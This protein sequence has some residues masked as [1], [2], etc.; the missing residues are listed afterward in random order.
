[1][2][3]NGDGAQPPGHPSRRAQRREGRCLSPPQG[4]EFRPSSGAGSLDGSAAETHAGSG[5]LPA[6]TPV[7]GLLSGPPAQRLQVLPE[8][9]EVFQEEGLFPRVTEEVGGVEEDHQVRFRIAGG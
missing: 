7:R 4:D 1:M 9:A 3:A 5:S 6:N 8:N 2:F